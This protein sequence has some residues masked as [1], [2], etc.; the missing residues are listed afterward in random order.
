MDPERD[1]HQ[2]LFVRIS[3]PFFIHNGSLAILILGIGFVC[4]WRAG[5]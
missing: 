5:I 1:V 3:L 2:L 4:D